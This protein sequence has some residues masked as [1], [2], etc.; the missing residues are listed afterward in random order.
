METKPNLAADV[1]ATRAAVRDTAAGALAA[2]HARIACHGAARPSQILLAK[3]LVRVA[4]DTLVAHAIAGGDRRSERAGGAVSKQCAAGTEVVGAR[5]Y[6]WS[7]AG[8][9]RVRRA[10]DLLVRIW[11]HVRKTMDGEKRKK[12]RH[13]KHKFK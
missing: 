1:D 10:T 8:V 4:T 5:A 7:R 9:Q 12:I 11:P 13:L 2:A 3:L 6:G